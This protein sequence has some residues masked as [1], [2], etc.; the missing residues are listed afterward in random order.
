MEQEIKIKVDNKLQFHGILKVGSTTP[1][2]L[3]F[4]TRKKKKNFSMF[5]YDV[6]ITERRK[7]LS[8]FLYF[9]IFN[10]IKSWDLFYLLPSTCVCCVYMLT[11]GGI[12]F[13]SFLI[14]HPLHLIHICIVL[15]EHIFLFSRNV[16]FVLCLILLSSST[17][18][19]VHFA[20]EGSYD[21]KDFT[22][23]NKKH[24]C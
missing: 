16:F 21:L 18:V 7:F 15:L 14:F 23:D 10:G 2:V 9:R 22:M 24:F 12:F 6:K 4:Q 5:S 20:S 8:R 19:L 1:P 13:L 3:Q 17:R 11:V